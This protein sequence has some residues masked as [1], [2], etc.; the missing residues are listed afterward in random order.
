MC[1]V[2]RRKHLQDLMI[3]VHDASSHHSPKMIKQ[4]K[5]CQAA[6]TVR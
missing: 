6:V 4:T 1:R 3:A 2:Q 5:N